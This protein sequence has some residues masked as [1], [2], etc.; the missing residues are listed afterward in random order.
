MTHKEVFIK[1]FS[2]FKD[3][4]VKN[5]L[6]ITIALNSAMLIFDYFVS[7]DDFIYYLVDRLFINCGISLLLLIFYNSK[8]VRKN[9]VYIGFGI[10]IITGVG[11]I[12]LLLV[13]SNI[14]YF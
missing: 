13:E 3:R 6:W 2:Q 9:F 10:Y 12:L 11:Q 7:K 5:I 1:E 8:V 4:D 14:Y